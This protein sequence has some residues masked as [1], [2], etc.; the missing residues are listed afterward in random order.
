MFRIVGFQRPFRQVQLMLP[1]QNLFRRSKYFSS[2]REQDFHP[3]LKALGAS[4]LWIGTG[5]IAATLLPVSIPSAATIFLYAYISSRAA[6]PLVNTKLAVQR[7]NEKLLVSSFPDFLKS[8]LHMFQKQL[9]KV[10]LSISAHR[11][12]NLYAFRGAFAKMLTFA[13]FDTMFALLSSSFGPEQIP[14]I[15]LIPIS[16]FLSGILQGTLVAIPEYLSTLQSRHPELPNSELYNQMWQQLQQT[17]GL[18]IWTVALRN[19]VLDSIFNSLRVAGGFSFGM[20]AVVAM[21]CN[22]PIERYRSLVH[23][24]EI[25]SIHMGNNNHGYQRFQGWFAKAVEFFTIYQCLQI[26]KELAIWT[27]S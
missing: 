18:P 5:S 17:K 4:T 7:N 1:I 16:G 20:S 12:G 2:Q 21:T 23:Q 13:G 27:S 9:S 24:H 6:Q 3:K 19:A 11:G 26:L 22:Y 14:H 25:T 10:G 15:I 8:E